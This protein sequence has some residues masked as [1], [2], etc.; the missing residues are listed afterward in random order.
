MRIYVHNMQATTLHILGELTLTFPW[1]APQ[2]GDSLRVL[3]L[4]TPGL[5]VHPHTAMRCERSGCHERELRRSDL[6]L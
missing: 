6:Q 3:R 1:F 5:E 4:R 2:K